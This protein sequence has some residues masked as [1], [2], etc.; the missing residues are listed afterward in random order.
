MS[1][2]SRSVSGW[3]VA[4]LRGVNVGPGNRVP[5]SELAAIVEACGY[6]RVRT[7]LNSG[8][9]VYVAPRVAPATAARRIAAGLADR[10]DVE[11]P[12]FVRTREQLHHLLT[13]NP[14]PREAASHPSAFLVMVW[15]EGAADAVREQLDAAPFTI[16]RAVVGSEVAYLSL[17]NGI[18][19]SKPLEQAM[20]QLGPRVTTRN[21]N[22]M[23][24]LRALMEDA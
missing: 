15:A 5:M 7:L 1:S 24:K 18:S 21:W 20:R 16:E 4:L 14:M 13:E 6:T 11:T 2:S 10:L 3:Q 23:R 19:A 17:P 22:T 12:V 9:V 8:N